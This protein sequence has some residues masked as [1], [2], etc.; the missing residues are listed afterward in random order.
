MTEIQEKV[1]AI[2]ARV[3]AEAWFVRLWND[4][5]ISRKMVPSG[6]DEGKYSDK[7]LVLFCHF[8]WEA[9]PDDRSCRTGPFF[10][11]CDI[12]EHIFD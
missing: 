12:A 5:L 9:L 6:I 11:L 1:K 4:T 2:Q 7:Q 8:M 10:Q 3:F